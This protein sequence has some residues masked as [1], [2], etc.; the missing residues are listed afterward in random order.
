MSSDSFLFAWAHSCATSSLRVNRVCVCSLCGSPGSL[1]FAWAHSFAP[2]DRRVYWGLRGFT[3]VRL[4]VIGFIRV[5]QGSLRRFIHVLL[6]SLRRTK[7][8]SGL[9]WFAW[10]HSGAPSARRDHLRS[11]GFTCVRLGVIGVIRVLVGS[12]RRS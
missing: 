2:R 12:L 7:W 3:R 6:G 11:C 5:R 10:F 1:T 8:W 9:F 4:R